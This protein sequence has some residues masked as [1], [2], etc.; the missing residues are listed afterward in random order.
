MTTWS[1]II[2]NSAMTF[3]NDD[4]MVDKLANNPARF[5][6][7]MSLFMRLAI[8]R[9]NRPVE[10]MQILARRTEP[11]FSSFLWTANEDT[12]PPEE[13]DE[14]E[15]PES[16]VS[17]G[18][19]GVRVYTGQIG[20]ELCSVVVRSLDRYENPVETP[21]PHAAY[22]PETG[23]VTFPEGIADGTVFDL[24]FYT[25]GQ[26][27]TDLPPEM[28]RILGLCIQSVWENR[29]TSAWL[30]RTAKVSDRSFTPPNEANWTRAQEEK[31]RSLEAT[32]NEELRHYEQNCAYRRVVNGAR[33]AL[34]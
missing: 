27:E 25:D 26:F 2:C 5:L 30:P 8:P 4:R 19:S 11:V 10:A 21:Y 28:A 13:P 24:D 23:I 6:R 16:P 9:F 15:N 17:P 29:F 1:E 32:L 18:A 20:F 31:R 34:L 22:D 3:I 33:G 7:E 14:E 12:T